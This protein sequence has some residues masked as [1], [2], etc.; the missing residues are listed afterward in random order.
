MS[1][2]GRVLLACCLISAVG[3]P[4]PLAVPKILVLSTYIVHLRRRGYDAGK[5]WAD[6]YRLLQHEVMVYDTSDS[7]K[8]PS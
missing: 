4:A 5:G 2:T 7:A 3:V 6:P 8:G 1:L